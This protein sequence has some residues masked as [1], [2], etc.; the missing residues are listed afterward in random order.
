LL[1]QLEN[2]G[3]ARPATLDS[4]KLSRHPYDDQY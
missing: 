4:N 1:K 3:Q 2:T